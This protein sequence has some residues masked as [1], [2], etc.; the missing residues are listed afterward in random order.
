MTA[1]R[2]R[3]INNKYITMKKLYVYITSS[4]YNIRHNKAY[5][6]FVIFG[7]A[8]TFIFI[9][10]VLQLTNEVVNNVPPF[11]NADRQIKIE[12]YRQYRSESGETGNTGFKL[13]EIPLFLKDVG[14]YQLCAIAYQTSESVFVNNRFLYRTL[15]AY[16]NGDYWRLNNFNFIKGRSFSEEET[17]SN[18]NV[19]IVSSA[20]A[21]ANFKTDEILG[22]KI[23]LNNR[24]YTIVGV[25][26]EYANLINYPAGIWVSYKSQPQNR[27]YNLDIL[28]NKEVE[29]DE[30]KGD[31]LQAMKRHYAKKSID[32]D[33]KSTEIVTLK[34][35]RIADVGG[36][37]LSYGISIILLILLIIPAINIVA[38][39]IA[40][41]NNRATEIAIRRSMG[42]S[43]FSS[44]ILIIVENLLLVVVG[45][46]VG[47]SLSFPMIDLMN[48]LSTNMTAFGKISFISSNNIW[49][50]I[51]Y[52]IPLALLFT[53]LSGGIP[54]YLIAKGKIAQV[55]KGD[56]NRNVSSNRRVSAIMVEQVLIFIILMIS[57]VFITTTVDRYYEPGLV[58]VDNVVNFSC[59]RANSDDEVSR[60]MGILVEDLKKNSNV[61]AFSVEREFAPYYF[62]PK[63]DSV[64]IDGVIIDAFIKY[65]DENTLN[66]FGLELIEGGWFTKETIAN[67][68]L[69]VVITQDIADKLN[70]NE[71]VGRKISFNGVDHIV[72]GVLD[73]F[74]QNTFNKH[75]P[76]I[77]FPYVSNRVHTVSVR[78]KDV[79]TFTVDLYN[80]WNKLMKDNSI[81]FNLAELEREKKADNL[82][83]IVELAIFGIPSLFLLIFAFI[84]TFGVFW[85][86]SQKRVKEFALRIAVGST[87]KRLMWLVIKESII[88]T[89][90]AMTPGLILACFIYEFT[91]VHAVAIVITIGFMFIFSIFSA[92]YPA[93]TVTKINPSIAL[94]DE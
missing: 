51:L 3:N 91:L 23:E 31:V 50:P 87:P 58:G 57:M 72:V 70:W 46:I 47:I 26:G 21:D 15:I 76:S 84:G 52:T 83:K 8:L 41:V 40:S 44:F 29:I 17:E 71:S 9:S 73:G 81:T 85:L 4:I 38:I 14:N 89:L 18:A 92:W 28:P 7:T 74:R 86:T 36:D 25:V 53:L 16:V 55:L 1:K 82:G 65:T 88:M 54:A 37:V 12:A 48:S 49:T 79:D 59:Y 20:F 60:K 80:Q 78:V 93:Y 33:M 27:L 42:A 11:V 45:V 63:C 62:Y 67:K 56:F 32:L 77:I 19:A 66:V 75:R 94:K 39:S 5:A 68:A 34:E 22:E 30:F 2:A 61:K 13:S 69:E 10:I 24:T 64:T 43:V 90:I 6:A 35:S